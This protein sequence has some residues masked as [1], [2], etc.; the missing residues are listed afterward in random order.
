M[1][2]QVVVGVGVAVGA[3]TAVASSGSS[4]Q[5]LWALINQYQLY[6]L[7]I[8]MQTYMPSDLQYYLI[9]FELFS[10]DFS[11]LDLFD[12]PVIE[13]KTFELHYDQEDTAF[14]ENGFESGSFLINH[15]NMFKA[16][17]VV[18]I[19]NL[20]FIAVYY[21]STK[22]RKGAKCR[23]VIDWF[24]DFFYLA[25]YIRVVIEAATFAFMS[26]L[27]ELTSVKAADTHIFSY[28]FSLVFTLVMIIV[29]IF[30]FIHYIKKNQN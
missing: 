18:F 12:I 22:F 24:K 23:K 17:L 9:E 15:W 27:L 4:T 6:L 14:G 16:L 13:K 5:G 21:I 29:P 25:T 1:V 26:S 2:T 28:I 8:Y 11:F 3:F 30:I 10:I 7:L 19:F 20:I